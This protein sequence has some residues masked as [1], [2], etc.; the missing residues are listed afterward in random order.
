M[1]PDKIQRCAPATVTSEVQLPN[2]LPKYISIVTQPANVSQDVHDDPTTSGSVS[3][4]YSDIISNQP[5]VSLSR[6]DDDQPKA[7]S[8]LHSI[9][10]NYATHFDFNFLFYIIGL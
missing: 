3:E 7:V 2:I 4:T 5:S 1:L 9:A 6:V 8:F 10:A